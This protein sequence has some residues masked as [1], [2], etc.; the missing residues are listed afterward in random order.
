MTDESNVIASCFETGNFPLIALRFLEKYLNHLYM[1]HDLH[2]K[3][4]V[5]N[6]LYF[7][8]ILTK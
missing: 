7:A 4:T 1:I 6:N 2:A 3:V 8:H 5:L